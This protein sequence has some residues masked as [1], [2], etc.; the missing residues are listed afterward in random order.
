MLEAIQASEG[1]YLTN[2]AADVVLVPKLFPGLGGVGRRR[3][4]LVLP[5]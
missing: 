2:M 1:S 3:R 4:F 5:L